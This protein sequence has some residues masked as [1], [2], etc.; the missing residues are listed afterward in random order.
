MSLEPR[1]VKMEERI[2]E[3]SVS[4]KTKQKNIKHR[5]ETQTNYNGKIPVIKIKQENPLDT[6]ETNSGLSEESIIKGE[7]IIKD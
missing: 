7:F 6:A 3:S 4:S 1:F 5:N 2:S